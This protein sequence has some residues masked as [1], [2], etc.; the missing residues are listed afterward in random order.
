MVRN[1]GDMAADPGCKVD[2]VI[3]TYGLESADPAFDTIDEGL[4]ARWKGA[5]DRP[6]MGYRPLTEWFN[7]RLLK[8]VYDE[9]GRDSL[10]ARLDSDYETLRSEDDLVREEMVERLHADGIA[11]GDLLEHMVS[12]GT[13]RTHLTECLDGEKARQTATTDW[14]KESITRAKDVVRSKTESA[15]SALSKKGDLAGG[16]TA[17][18]EVQIQLSCAS[19]PTRV[20]FDVAYERGYVCEQHSR[21]HASANAQ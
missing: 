16:A 9:H 13:M 2:T 19:C 6:A 3:E 8:H 10:G 12:W 21:T 14:E 7:K 20:T 18:I 15:L 5:D 1:Y 11:G 17:D 4:L